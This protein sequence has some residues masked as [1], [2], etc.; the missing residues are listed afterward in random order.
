MY[1]AV[2]ARAKDTNDLD[3]RIKYAVENFRSGAG[4]HMRVYY[5][6][7]FLANLEQELLDRGFKNID[8]PDITLKG[9]VYFEW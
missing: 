3:E 1:T 7:S 8:I 5:D 4:A 9:D 2:D 6:D